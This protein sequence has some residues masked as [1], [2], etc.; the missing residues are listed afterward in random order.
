MGA[1]VPVIPM[2]VWGSQRVWTKGVPRNLKRQKVPVTIAIG[3][4]IFFAKGDDVEQ[5]E[6]ALRSTMI[7]MLHEV[8]ESYPDGHSGQWWAPVRLGGTAPAPL[9]S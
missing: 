7:S 3:K 9:N 4:P 2:I 1:G 6:I 5:A 8:Q